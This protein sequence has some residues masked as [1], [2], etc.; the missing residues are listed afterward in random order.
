MLALSSPCSPS[1]Y[2]S[3]NTRY[4]HIILQNDLVD[5]VK[6]RVGLVAACDEQFAGGKV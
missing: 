5:G 2:L 6:P 4:H 3:P 1:E